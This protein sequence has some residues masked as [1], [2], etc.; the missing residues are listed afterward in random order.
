MNTAM[1]DHVLTRRQLNIFIEFGRIAKN[2]SD[3]DQNENNYSIVTIVE[4]VVKKLAC[5]DIGAGALADLDDIIDRVKNCLYLNDYV[6]E[7][8]HIYYN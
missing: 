1:W 5:G 6:S 4:P 3:A 8:C 2:L 7:A